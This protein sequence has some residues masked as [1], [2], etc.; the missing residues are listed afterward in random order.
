MAEAPG[1]GLGGGFSHGLD[2]HRGRNLMQQRQELL[3]FLLRAKTSEAMV[4]A[5]LFIG[6]PGRSQGVTPSGRDRGRRVRRPGGAGLLLMTSVAFLSLFARVVGGGMPESGLGHGAIP[7]EGGAW[8]GGGGRRVSA[9]LRGAGAAND[10]KA[11]HCHGGPVR[12]NVVDDV[13][14]HQGAEGRPGGLCF[15]VDKLARKGEAADMVGISRPF[16]GG[17]TTTIE[18]RGVGLLSR[19]RGGGNCIGGV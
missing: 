17:T 16:G 5:P 15:T 11:L 18:D 9:I 4:V 3:I 7:A 6:G 8:V 13:P 14:H 19:L 2:R 12:H 10:P 1:G